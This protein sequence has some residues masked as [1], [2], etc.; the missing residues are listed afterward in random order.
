MHGEVFSCRVGSIEERGRILGS[1]IMCSWERNTKMVV[2]S[3]DMSSPWWCIGETTNVDVSREI[4]RFSVYVRLLSSFR[5]CLPLLHP[6][7]HRSINL[8]SPCINTAK[9]TSTS[10]S[11]CIRLFLAVSARFFC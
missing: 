6:I 10:Y 11:K 2:R 9:P 1:G 3:S 4:V 7:H 8:I 5:H